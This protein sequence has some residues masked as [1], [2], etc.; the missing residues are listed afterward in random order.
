MN[1]PKEV[2]PVARYKIYASNTALLQGFVGIQSLTERFRMTADDF[3][4]L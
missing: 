1:L 2:W 4:L 3:T